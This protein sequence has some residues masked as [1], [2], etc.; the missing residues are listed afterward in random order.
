MCD[1][2]SA[3]AGTHILYLLDLLLSPL[4]TSN[5]SQHHLEISGPPLRVAARP[6]A[7]KMFWDF[8][9]AEIQIQ[10]LE[11]LI[12]DSARYASVCRAWQTIIE[13]R[14]F[15]RLKITR[16]RLAN[17]DIGYRHRHLVKYIWFSIE[18]SEY[19]CPWCGVEGIY[20][21]HQVPP[22]I[23]KKAIQDLVIQLSTWEPSDGLVLDISVKT[24]RA[25]S[26]STTQYGPAFISEPKKANQCSHWLHDPNLHDAAMYLIDR[27]TSVPETELGQEIPKARAVTSLLLRR[28][29]RRPWKS[30]VLEELVNLL[31]KVQEIYYE[32][33]KGWRRMEYRRSTNAMRLF[34][35]LGSNQLR[36][37]VIFEDF[38]G[39]N[40]LATSSKVQ[41][42][43]TEVLV[44]A[45]LGLEYLAIS[46]ISD[47]SH[48]FHTRQKW[49]IWPRLESLA[50][51][52]NVLKPQQQHVNN[53]LETAA[54]VTRKMPRLKS[55]ELWNGGAG[56]AGVFQYQILDRAV[57][58]T[59]RG[60]WNLLLGP[61]VLEAWQAVASE[62]VDCKLQVVTEMLDVVVT[63]H[64]DAIRHLRLLNNV[65]HP[66]SL[67]QIQKETTP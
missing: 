37:M 24:P 28:Q 42:T 21:Q 45:S 29:T 65:A 2:T 13:Q 47:A 35:S 9:P 63:S 61:S 67:W 5:K 43:E 14:N 56:F 38:H 57:K 40:H 48:F 6:A 17:F 7:Y 3:S 23:I 60:T 26:S 22:K 58:I 30:E 62:R 12:L 41:A 32:P 4:N 59:W 20:D 39:N 27:T 50:L 31:P 54:L 51:T 49:R 66:V 52:S 15:A 19:Y 33:W 11:A 46:F 8:L 36:R 34:E 25:W 18:P 55:M 44:Q 10:I 1:F 64:S 16:A 53:F